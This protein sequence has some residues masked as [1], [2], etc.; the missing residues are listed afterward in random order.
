MEFTIGGTEE[1]IT[2]AIATIREAIETEVRAESRLYI[3]KLKQ[4]IAD[5]ENKVRFFE[6]TESRL[7]KRKQVMIG[8]ALQV[9]P[10]APGSESDTLR[11]LPSKSN[12]PFDKTRPISKTIPIR[13][14]FKISLNSE[15]AASIITMLIEMN[16]VQPMGSKLDDL[17]ISAMK[18]I[19]SSSSYNVKPAHISALDISMKWSVNTIYPALCAFWVGLLNENLNAIFCSVKSVRGMPPKGTEIILRLNKLLVSNPPN[20]VKI[21]YCRALG[22]AA[23]HESGRELIMS[24][25]RTV[26]KLIAIQLFVTDDSVQIAAAYAFCN[27]ARLLLLKTESDKV[28]AELGSRQD[29]LEVIISVIEKLDS[30]TSVSSTVL[31]RLLQAIGTLM[32]GSAAVI[33]VAKNRGV[34]S[35]VNKIK[36]CVTDDVAKAACR[37]ITE[38]VLAI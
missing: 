9:Y 8:S 13:K 35:I 20:P 38:M 1:K 30:F 21:L 31:I 26:S 24:E 4:R 11:T 23:V 22:N 33:G 7:R 18:E 16:N 2:K 14:F 29:V 36:D 15:T 25:I 12:R 37:D 27:F 17:Q 5:L 19:I 32:W 10:D 28:E 34:L 3:L 6:S